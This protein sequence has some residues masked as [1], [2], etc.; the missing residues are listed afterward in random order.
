MNGKKGRGRGFAGMSEEKRRSIAS[1]GAR[2]AHRS[3]GAHEFTSEEGKS[4]GKKGG[5]ARARKNKNRDNDDDLGGFG[6][7]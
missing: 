5:M 6:R 3:G 2:A 7:F 4:A 1:K